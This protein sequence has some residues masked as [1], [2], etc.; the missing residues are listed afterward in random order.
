MSTGKSNRMVKRI[1]IA[2]LR[3]PYTTYETSLARYKSCKYFQGWHR[4]A[5]KHIA[6]P[7]RLHFVNILQNEENYYENVGICRENF[8]SG[9]CCNQTVSSA[10]VCLAG[11]LICRPANQLSDTG[12][13]FNLIAELQQER[14][15]NSTPENYCIFGKGKGT[16]DYTESG[17]V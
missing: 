16:Q 1:F 11:Y 9:S 8:R 13:S 10:A 15:R 7:S 2:K 3:T 4:P 5:T 12:S 14:S 17:M 6:K